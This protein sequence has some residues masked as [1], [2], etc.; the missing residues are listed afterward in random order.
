MALSVVAE[1]GEGSAASGYLGDIVLACL[2]R[3][4]DEEVGE[5]AKELLWRF[6]NV[7]RSEDLKGRIR[8]VVSVP[9]DLG[10]LY[11]FV[12]ER[13]ERATDGDKNVFRTVVGAL[14]VLNWEEDLNGRADVKVLQMF[15]SR[16]TKQERLRKRSPARSSRIEGGL[17]EG[18]DDE[19][20]GEEEL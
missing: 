20:A 3:R 15:V 11:A 12:V 6:L 7:A 16:A 19:G 2:R 18:A 8:D 13:S 10:W 14:E 9:G 4:G 5:E 1:W 17:E